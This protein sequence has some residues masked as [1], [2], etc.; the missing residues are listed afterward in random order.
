ME[1][2]LPRR[3][4]PPPDLN[5]ILFG[6][7]ISRLQGPTD[8]LLPGVYSPSPKALPH[9]ME[10]SPIHNKQLDN[11]MSGGYRESPGRNPPHRLLP[12]P[13]VDLNGVELITLLIE[14]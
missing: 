9:Y 6:L 11:T 4:V 14:Q 3:E 1:D 7:I 12:E 5:L 8:E 13:P 10:R 2:P